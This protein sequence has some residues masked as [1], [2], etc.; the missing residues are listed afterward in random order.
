M[1]KLIAIFCFVM[2]ASFA[3]FPK[4]LSFTDVPENQWYYEDVKGAVESGIINGKSETVFAPDDNLTYAEAI[5]LAACMHQLYTEGAVTLKNGNPWY[6]PY[7]EYCLDNAIITTDFFSRISNPDEYATRAGYM[8]IFANALPDE[9][10]ADINSIPD[11]SILDVKDN[12]PYAIYVYKMYRAGIVTGVDAEHRCNPDANIL[13]CEVATIISRMMDEDKRVRFDM[14]NPDAP[15]IIED[16]VKVDPDIHPSIVVGPEKDD[17][18]FD[19]STGDYVL[20][21]LTIYKQPEGLEAEIYGI[22]VELEVQVYGGKAPYSYK[23]FYYTGNRNDTAEIANG[24]YIKDVTSDALVVSVEKENTYLGRG[25]YCV[26]TDSAGESVQTNT[27]KVYGPFSM[28]ADSVTIEEAVKKY[29][30]AGQIADGIIR[31]GDKVSVERNGKIIATG[32]AVEL[33]MFGK[34]LDD[35]IKGDRV[36]IVFVLD[37]GASPK[38]GDTVIKYKDS[39]IVDTSDIVN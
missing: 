15:G 31:K 10:F 13:R 9:A 6:S 1:K 7:L 26:I 28:P 19:V 22:K 35:G 21:P 16:N 23:W 12:A 17:Q 2:L 5:K 34:S 3:V 18:K 29:T 38:S 24:D 27:V 8:M 20:N 4:A 30:V 25:I 37:K 11:G 33:Q 36:G 14:V 39:H 32:T